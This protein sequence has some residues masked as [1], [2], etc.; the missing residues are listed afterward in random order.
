MTALSGSRALPGDL[1]HTRET[2]R[3]RE[4][5]P[6][7]AKE[8]GVPDQVPVL[9]VPPVLRVPCLTVAASDLRVVAALS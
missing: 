4:T 7:E 6:R 1:R 3:H 5:W 8:V 2:L 9:Q